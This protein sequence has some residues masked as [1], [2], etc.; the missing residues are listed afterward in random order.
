[1][2]GI[3][4][5]KAAQDNLTLSFAAMFAPKVKVNSIAPALISFRPDDSSNYRQ[6]AVQKNLMGHE[7]G[8][9]EF[10]NAIDYLLASRYKQDE[11]CLSMVVGTFVDSSLIAAPQSPQVPKPRTFYQPLRR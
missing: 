2:I 9:E 5:T 4:L 7:G 1:M 3:F 6:A 8:H 11:H 10:M